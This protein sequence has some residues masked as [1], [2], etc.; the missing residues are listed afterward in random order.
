MASAIEAGV[1]RALAKGDATDPDF[2]VRIYEAS[3]RA[4]LRV[5]EEKQLSEAEVDRRRTELIA[6]VEA[7]E[8]EYPY[9]PPKESD[10]AEGPDAAV[11]AEETLAEPAATAGEPAP[12]MQPEDR[13]EDESSASEPASSGGPTEDPGQPSIAA[14]PT[15]SPGRNRAAGMAAGRR[16]RRIAIAAIALLV[17]AV[18]V[19]VIAWYLSGATR[20]A[21]TTQRAEP[22]GPSIEDTIRSASE[23]PADTSSE[24][25]PGTIVVFAGNSP[26]TVTSAQGGRI[27][28]IKGPDGRPGV[29]IEPPPGQGRDTFG[30]LLKPGVADQIA[31]QRT[32]FEITVGS[33]DGQK[34]E[35]AIS[36]DFKGA[37]D[38]GRQRFSTSQAQETF[39][40]EAQVPPAVSGGASLVVD[41]AIGQD[42][43]DL[44]IFSL[45]AKP[46]G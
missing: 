29:H 13:A 5:A 18:I 11:P 28:T 24:P 37:G 21:Q 30:L 44:N 32:K 16:G 1:R 39:L 19:A 4:I 27:T 14:D 40:F 43:G 10:E 12:E 41:P 2:R 34:R 35:F 23:T 36:C 3:E 15:W 42:P 8:A 26:D 17:L 45:W 9:V 46:G 22:T 38:C 31:G 7:I 25:G 33:P 6:A 20:T